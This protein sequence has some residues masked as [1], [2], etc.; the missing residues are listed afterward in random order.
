MKALTDK[1]KIFCEEY[2]KDFN[3][4]RA[5]IAAGYSSN[6]ARVRAVEL[7]AKPQVKEFIMAVRTDQST[8]NLVT[9]DYITQ[10]LKEIAEDRDAPTAA[11][12]TAFTQLGK[13]IGAFVERQELE[14][15]VQV[16]EVVR[17][18]VREK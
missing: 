8:S 14:Q 11:R 4:S 7:L 5:A 3:G 18:I 16:T 15:S 10:G 13:M 6:G 2:L 9:L 12:V 1:Q 17:K